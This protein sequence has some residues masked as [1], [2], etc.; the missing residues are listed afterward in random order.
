MKRTLEVSSRLTYILQKKI[1]KEESDIIN[2]QPSN[3]Y[4][5]HWVCYMIININK[6]KDFYDVLYS[7]KQLPCKTKPSLLFLAYKW[8][9]L[10]DLMPNKEYAIIRVWRDGSAGPGDG[11]TL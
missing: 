8:L 11:I 5:S 9:T 2:F 1:R 6:G 4:G 3:S 10:L 7:F